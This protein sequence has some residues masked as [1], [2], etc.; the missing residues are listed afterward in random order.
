MMRSR[1]LGNSLQFSGSTPK[2]SVDVA[3][4]QIAFYF[5]VLRYLA[6]KVTLSSNFSSDEIVNLVSLIHHIH[7]FIGKVR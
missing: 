5:A 1:C 6:F 4:S 7:I 2:L 3:T